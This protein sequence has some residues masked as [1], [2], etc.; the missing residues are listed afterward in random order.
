MGRGADLGD[1][2]LLLRHAVLDRVCS[3]L[4]VAI[5]AAQVMR[6]G[7]PLRELRP[8]PNV[9]ERDDLTG[10]RQ[11]RIEDLAGIVRDAMSSMSF[12]RYRRTGAGP[13]WRCT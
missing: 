9:S 7:S 5:S 11:R 4:P 13:P 6:L 1:D 8:L 12:G 3:V 10:E 2:E